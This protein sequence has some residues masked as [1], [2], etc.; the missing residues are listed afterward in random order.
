MKSIMMSIK[1][2]WV[3]KILNGEKTVEVRKTIPRCKPPFKVYI[4][5]TKGNTYKESKLKGKVVG[6]FICDKIDVLWKS[7][8]NLKQIRKHTCYYI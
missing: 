4:Y 3:E 5:C 2:E 8:Q 7:T 1:P 6:E